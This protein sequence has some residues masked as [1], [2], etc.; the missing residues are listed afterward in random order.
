MESP[1]HPFYETVDAAN[2][3]IA[4]GHTVWQKFTCANCS[5]R[6]TMGTPDTFYKTGTCEECNHITNIEKDGCN[7]IMLMTNDPK[8]REAARKIF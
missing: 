2:K 1:N 4:K 6:Q 7:F 5:S 8:L 3:E